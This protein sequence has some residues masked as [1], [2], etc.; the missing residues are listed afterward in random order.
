MS[1]SRDLIK[2]WYAKGKEKGAT[3]MIIVCDT[4]EYEDFPVYVMPTESAREKAQ[5]ESIKPMQ[6]VME[7]YSLS[8]PVL[9]Q[10]R[11]ARAF[12]YD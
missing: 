3:H 4:L 9:D 8:L 10:Y 6:R 5:A 12:H 1:V 11:E 2:E 7:V